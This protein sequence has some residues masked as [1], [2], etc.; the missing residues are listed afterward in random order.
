MATPKPMPVIL[1]GQHRVLMSYSEH[2]FRKECYAPIC[3][4]TTN[5]VLANLNTAMSGALGVVIIDTEMR[6]GEEFSREETEGGLYTGVFLYRKIREVHPRKPVVLLTV[7]PDYVNER[8]SLRD[9]KYLQ[10]LSLMHV[11][12]SQHPEILSRLA[13]RILDEP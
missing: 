2:H 4:Y 8:F 6:H 3:C 9:D 7:G 1:I 13:M 12:P 5:D 10:V 11:V